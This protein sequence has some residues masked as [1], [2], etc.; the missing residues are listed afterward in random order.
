MENAVGLYGHGGGLVGLDLDILVKKAGGRFK[1]VTLIQRRMRDLQ[2]GAPPLI[3]HPTGS[4]MQTALE[5]YYQDKIWPVQGE[6]AEKLR[7][8]RESD[9]SARASLRPPPGGAAGAGS[10]GATG[11]APKAGA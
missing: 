7:A 6:E 8:A 10:S 5:E 3:E 11:T 9:R 2:R 4:L 1:F